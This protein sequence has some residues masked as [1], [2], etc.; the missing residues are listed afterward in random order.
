VKRQDSRREKREPKGNIH[1]WATRNSLNPLRIG[2]TFGKYLTEKGP[3]QTLEITLDW[4]IDYYLDWHFGI[5]TS[6]VVAPDELRYNNPAYLFYQPTV[7]RSIYKTLNS[8]NIARGNS[9]FLDYGCGMGRVLIAAAR[10]PFR[11]V[12]GIELSP[13]LSEI[14][15]QNIRKASPHLK[16]KDVQVV[17]QDA[18]SYAVP[19]DADYFFFFHPFEGEVMARVIKNIHTSLL[20]HPRQITILYIPIYTNPPTKLDECNWLTKRGEKPIFPRYRNRVLR[21]Y[22]NT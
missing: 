4:L 12:I 14:A 3:G 5:N 9:V 22:A 2:R 19:A 7:Y 10:Y 20:D 6:N 18:V 21:I 16:C 17:N 13:E 15:N 11:K 8:T 1:R